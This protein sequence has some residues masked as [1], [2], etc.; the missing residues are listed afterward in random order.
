MTQVHVWVVHKM[1]DRVVVETE[2]FSSKS[3]AE[4]YLMMKGY[5]HEWPRRPRRDPT[6]HEWK[7]TKRNP[8]QSY[9]YW[10]ERKPLK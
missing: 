4:M 3:G 10:L 5:D 1:L 2:V 6:G 8:E 9:T 7:P